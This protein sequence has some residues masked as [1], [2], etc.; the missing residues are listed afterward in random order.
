[1]YYLYF[2]HPFIYYQ[3]SKPYH[4]TVPSSEFSYLLLLILHVFV[5]VL[6]DSYK[7]RCLVLSNVHNWQGSCYFIF[8]AEFSR[9]SISNPWRICISLKINWKQRKMLVLFLNSYVIIQ[10][11]SSS[12]PVYIS[13]EDFGFVFS[14]SP[15][16]TQ[17]SFLHMSSISTSS[18]H[19]VHLHCL[20]FFQFIFNLWIFFI[21]IEVKE[22]HFYIPRPS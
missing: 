19:C 17:A 21:F 15:L 14:H 16:N 7:E 22:K 5:R 6:W 12:C 1:M 20:L 3:N 11:S 9:P 4:R 18:Q 10:H 2:F 13:G 8:S